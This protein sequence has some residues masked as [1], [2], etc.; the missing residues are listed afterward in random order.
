MNKSWFLDFVHIH[1][2]HHTVSIGI[3]PSSIKNFHL[4]HVSFTWRC[5]MINRVIISSFI[6]RKRNWHFT[7][8]IL[9]LAI[10]VIAD[11]KLSRSGWRSD[12]ETYVPYILQ[13]T[14]DLTNQER[15]SPF[16]WQSSTGFQIDD[17]SVAL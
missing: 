9:L 13:G 12:F 8:A 17:S 11:E 14:K 15:V 2:L 7:I 6:I 16:L 4:S 3:R 1:S 10:S 5:H